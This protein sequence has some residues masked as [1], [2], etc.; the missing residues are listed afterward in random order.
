MS[1][2]TNHTLLFPHTPPP[3]GTVHVT[4]LSLC[5]TIST[6]VLLLSILPSSQSYQSFRFVRV[7]YKPLRKQPGGE[8]TIAMIRRL[9]VEV[10]V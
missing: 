3:V 7:S 5:Y 2:V 9:G 1:C 4:V 10:L 8:G 6:F